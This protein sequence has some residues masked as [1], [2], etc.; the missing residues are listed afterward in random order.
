[1]PAS[2]PGCGRRGSCS[3][4][5][6]PLLVV[7]G[8]E[9]GMRYGVVRY[10]FRQH[11][12]TRVDRAAKQLADDVKSIMLNAGGPTAAQT[13]H[14]IGAVGVLMQSL[15]D[16]AATRALAD[17]AAQPLR[18]PLARLRQGFAAIS[19]ALLAAAVPAAVPE[20]QAAGFQAF[21]QS[22]REL[23]MLEAT[24]Q[25]V[26]ESGPQLVHRLAQG[27]PRGSAD[28]APAAACCGR[29]DGGAVARPGGLKLRPGVGLVQEPTMKVPLVTVAAGAVVIGCQRPAVGRC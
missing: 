15:D 4:W 26:A 1:M 24:L 7:A 23:A 19:A 21:A 17:A 6:L 10:D 9:L 20:A 5:L 18:H 11:E 14:S 12:P 8:A 29:G 27:K 3:G 2:W 13:V 28:G 25:T 16:L 22:L